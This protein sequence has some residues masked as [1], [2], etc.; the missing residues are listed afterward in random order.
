M[1]TYANVL[2]QNVRGR[3]GSDSSSIDSGMCSPTTTRAQQQNISHRERC[4]SGAK[5]VA[6]SFHSDD[7]TTSEPVRSELIEECDYDIPRDPEWEIER[8]R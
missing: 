8:E 1:M 3:R 5:R 6:I 2:S 4:L 7:D